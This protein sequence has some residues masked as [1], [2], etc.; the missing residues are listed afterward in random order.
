[1]PYRIRPRSRKQRV[2]FALRQFRSRKQRVLFALRQFRG[3]YAFPA[4]MTVLVVFWL[5][6]AVKTVMWKVDCD[7]H[8]GVYLRGAFSYECIVGG[9]KFEGDK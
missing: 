8:G 5:V 4:I 7:N 9:H 3:R 1:M 6:M 2:L